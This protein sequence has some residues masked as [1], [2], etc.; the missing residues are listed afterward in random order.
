MKS[1]LKVISLLG[2]FLA[3]L[4]A[5][6]NLFTISILSLEFN[7]P[8]FLEDF[9]S[10][11]TLTEKWHFRADLKNPGTLYFSQQNSHSGD[12]SLLHNESYTGLIRDFDESY[13]VVEI[14]MYDNVNVIGDSVHCFYVNNFTGIAVGFVKGW[15]DENYYAYSVKTGEVWSPY[16]EITTRSPI[17]HN[18]TYV[19]DTN[20]ITCF[21]DNTLFYSQ[22]EFGKI[23][24]IQIADNGHAN[25]NPEVFYDDVSFR[26]LGTPS[27]LTHLK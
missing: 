13:G 16:Q 23:V 10:Q 19:I 24:S 15:H 4:L 27:P 7:P 8:Y 22:N 17:W 12:Y 2:I 5:S 3:I 21:L 20:G 18:F 6:T 26:E 14:W 1:I 25:T 9:E 11:T